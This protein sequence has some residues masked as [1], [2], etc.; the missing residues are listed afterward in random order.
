MQELLLCTYL[1]LIPTNQHNQFS[2]NMSI[3]MLTKEDV[4]YL[5]NKM[6]HHFVSKEVKY[7]P[8]IVW[9]THNEIAHYVSPV[10]TQGDG[11]LAPLHLQTRTLTSYFQGCTICST[12]AH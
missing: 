10:K 11:P 2:L 1:T 9:A 6:K 3:S 8:K 7:L 4:M 5:Y 12:N